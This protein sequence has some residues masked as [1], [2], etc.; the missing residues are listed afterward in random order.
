MLAPVAE[1]KDT[2]SN[3]QRGLNR[4]V[5]PFASLRPR[6]DTDAAT[7]RHHLRSVE[8]GGTEYG[9]TKRFTHSVAQLFG[10]PDATFHL[11]TPDEVFGRLVNKGAAKDVRV[12]SYRGDLLGMSNPGRSVLNTSRLEDFLN[13]DVTDHRFKNGVLTLSYR[14]GGEFESRGQ[15]YANTFSVQLPMDGASKICTYLGILRLACMNGAVAESSAFRSEI[16]QGKGNDDINT[17]VSRIVNNFRNDEGFD[18]LQRR[19]DEAN[20]TTASVSEVSQIRK[21]VHDSRNLTPVAKTDFLA[22]ID[23]F[24]GT[25][26][27]MYDTVD[28]AISRRR[29][30]LLPTLATVGDLINAAS[31]LSTHHAPDSTN[32]ING[33]IG[34]K[35][36]AEYDLE[37][38]KSDISG[39]NDRAFLFARAAS[40]N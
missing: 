10:V 22:A 35:L 2:I 27:G 31:E 36:T 19:I 17:V 1:V 3:I 30:T 21:I 13:P 38:I 34:S 18:A 33:W 40:L 24:A 11:F 37:S 29:A 14:A 12:T 25:N 5:V 20:N 15:G 9:V 39:N 32:S 8:Y 23:G 28:S 7:G 16:Q 26:H 6:W 4:D